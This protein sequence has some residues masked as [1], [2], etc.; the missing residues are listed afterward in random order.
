[1]CGKQS[2]HD[3]RPWL[4]AELVLLSQQSLLAV[5]MGREPG[6]VGVKKGRGFVM[7][8]SLGLRSDVVCIYINGN[9]LGSAFQQS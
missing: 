8:P 6:S 1:M 5:E 4:I 7:S 9:K 2:L 3:D